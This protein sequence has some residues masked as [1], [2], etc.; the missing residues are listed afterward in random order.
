[1]S[2]RETALAYARIAGYHNDKAAF[3]RL[4]VESK[5]RLEL[6]NDAWRVGVKQ[7][8]AGVKC[9]CYQCNTKGA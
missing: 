1:M 9:N 5:V 4:Y 7:K 2:K 8:L 6:M 3:T